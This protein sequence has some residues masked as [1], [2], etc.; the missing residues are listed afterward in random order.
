[1]RSNNLKK[2]LGLMTALN[3]NLKRLPH[4]LW[5]LPILLLAN[6]LIAQH[7][8][9]D[10]YWFDEIEN[11][12]LM[13]LPPQESITSDTLL[14]NISV[15]RWPPAY[16][17]ELLLWGNLVGWSEFATRSLSL[18]IGVL[19][20]AMMYQLGI[21]FHNRRVGIIAT[22][23]LSTSVFF[24]FY[25]HEIRGYIQY[26]LFTIIVLHLYWHQRK[27]R[28]LTTKDSILFVT[29]AAIL[30]YTHY[31]AL[32]IIFVLGVYHLFFAKRT[33]TWGKSLR[34]FIYVGITYI[35][36][37]AIAVLNAVG[38]TSMI[39]ESSLQAIFQSLT[40]GFSNG[41]WFILLLFISYI[42]VFIRTRSTGMLVFSGILFL[43]ASLLTNTL[44][45][46]LFHVRH[47]IGLLPILLL[48]SAMAI[49][50]MLT[51]VHKV[52]W[53]LVIVWMGVGTG[54]NRDLTFMNNLPG[55]LETRPLEMLTTA[56]NITSTCTIEDDLVVTHLESQENI[57][58]KYVE[59]HYFWHPDFTIAMIDNMVDFSDGIDNM[60]NDGTYETRLQGYIAD[61]DQTWVMVADDA[62]ITPR[63]GELGILLEENYS[64]CDRIYR[65]SNM[66]I[67]IYQ[68]ESEFSCP[69]EYLSAQTLTN[70]T[71][72]LLIDASVPSN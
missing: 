57:W 49:D 14:F 72:N 25:A 18:F 7:L 60:Q 35:P 46:F 32:Y 38:E 45:D 9:T 16:S 10:A 40:N 3:Q 13:G 56:Q 43:V 2:G 68:Q 58:N 20:V 19:S 67:Y 44:L 28:R 50:H 24:L 70:C 1:M 37:I 66:S 11:F 15:N 62:Y 51:H 41:L 31:V 29:S 27:K 65:G 42:L 5:I 59:Q 53:V 52:T 21:T 64:Y 55:A 17:F 30:I 63:L 71:P 8:T 36:W 23:L 33:P 12:R 22:L 26:V 54:L 69:S 61:A 39:R 48:L 4:W 34:L 6:I 47:L